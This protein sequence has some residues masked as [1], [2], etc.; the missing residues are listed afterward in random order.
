MGLAEFMHA[1]AVNAEEFSRAP[2]FASLVPLVDRMYLTASTLAANGKRSPTLLKLLWLAQRDFLVAASQIQR[3]L[4]FDSHANTRRAV[5]IA[6]V[7]LALKRNLKNAD[8]WLNEE[9]R[10]RRWDARQSGRK[11]EWMPPVRFP[12]LDNEPLLTQLG[13]YFGIAS[14]AY[15]H[16][17]PEYLGLQPISHGPSDRT[18]SRSDAVRLPRP[19]TVGVQCGVRRDRSDRSRMER[20]AYHLRDAG[21]GSVSRSAATARRMISAVRE[22]WRLY[23]KL[24]V[25]ER[26]AV[27]T[28]V[29]LFQL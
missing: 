24:L 1:Q 18:S 27:P 20:A 10:Q 17:T 19:C 21:A 16:F 5:E 14:D 15:L 25:P 4:P 28:E 9:V 2:H 3:A 11:P 23:G 7:A 29:T 22:S 26:L 12:E 8:R 13:E 6:R